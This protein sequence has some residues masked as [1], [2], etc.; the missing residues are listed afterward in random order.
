MRKTKIVMPLLLLG[1]AMVM[2][3][4]KPPQEAIDSANQSIESARA[5]GAS[6]YAPESLRMAEDKL[7]F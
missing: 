1:L 7:F 6:D 3:C 4:A 2:G 5:A